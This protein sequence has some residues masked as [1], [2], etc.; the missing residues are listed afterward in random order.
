[1]V[2]AQMRVAGWDNWIPRDSHLDIMSRSSLISS[3]Y[4]MVYLREQPSQLPSS[5]RL[6]LV[7]EW[8]QC[9][10][11]CREC[12]RAARKL[13]AIPNSTARRYLIALHA[14]HAYVNMERGYNGSAP[15]GQAI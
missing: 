1:M 7:I 9:R 6:R 8:L 13:L 15:M 4:A 14:V 10:T 3:P 5:M 11:S 12:H 2:M